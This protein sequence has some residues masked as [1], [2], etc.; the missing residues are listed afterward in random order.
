MEDKEIIYSLNGAADY[1]GVTRQAV[2]VALTKMRIKYRKIDGKIEI[3]KGQLDAYKASRYNRAIT[4]KVNG[5]LL[6]G[7]NFVNLSM[8]QEVSKIPRYHFYFAIR[9]GRIPYERHGCSYVLRLV[10]VINYSQKYWNSKGKKM[11]QLVG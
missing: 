10:D 2:Y 11:G 5:S 7:N 1:L 6:Y 4:T 3:K 9:N 8:A